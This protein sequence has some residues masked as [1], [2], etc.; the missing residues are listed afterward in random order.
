MQEGRQLFRRL[1]ARPLTVVGAS[2]ECRAR[3][4]CGNRLRGVERLA[5]ALAQSPGHSFSSAAASYCLRAQDFYS[6]IFNRHSKR[7]RRFIQREFDLPQPEGLGWSSLSFLYL[8]FVI[9][10]GSLNVCLTMS[11]I[12]SLIAP[13]A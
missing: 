8:M 4:R 11:V 2:V 13:C 1:R 12:R 6:P 5:D 10:N 3:V 7:S 9:E